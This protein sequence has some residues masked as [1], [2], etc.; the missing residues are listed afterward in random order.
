MLT[1]RRIA[2]IRQTSAARLGTLVFSVVLLSLCFHHRTSG[3]QMMKYYLAS[4]INSLL[5]TFA[6]RQSPRVS[7]DKLLVSHQLCPLRH[8]LVSPLPLLSQ[9]K[10][11]L[12]LPLLVPC[13]KAERCIYWKGHIHYVP[14]PW[15]FQWRVAVEIVMFINVLATFCLLCVHLLLMSTCCFSWMELGTRP[16]NRKWSHK[17]KKKKFS[18]LQRLLSGCDF[19]LICVSAYLLDSKAESRL[20]PYPKRLM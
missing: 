2:S 14:Q 11:T 7:I 18:W 12:T 16:W 13:L 5:G 9:R 15:N 20:T 1:L 19:D 8:A 10:R 4:V 6:S 3:N 17:K